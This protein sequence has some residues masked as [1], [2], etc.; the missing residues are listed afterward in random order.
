M[1]QNYYKPGTWN[2]IC[3]VC[4]IQVKSDAI[5]KRWDGVLVCKDDF[6]VRHSLDFLRVKTER[7]SIPFTAPE[8]TDAFVDVFYLVTALAGIAIAGRSISGLIVET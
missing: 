8:P 3:A 7:G 4:G 5:L 2:C 6:E 1:A